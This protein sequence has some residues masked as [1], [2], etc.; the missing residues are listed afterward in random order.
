M[1]AS[2]LLTHQMMIWMIWIQMY[3]SV[4]PAV[5]AFHK[6]TRHVFGWGCSKQAQAQPGMQVTAS[7]GQKSRQY[8]CLQY[9]A[10][11]RTLR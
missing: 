10:A 9:S 11:E 5:W 6:M 8:H 7:S 1:R 3:V 2:R 4:D